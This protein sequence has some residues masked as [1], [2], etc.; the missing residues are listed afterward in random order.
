LTLKMLLTAVVSLGFAATALPAAAAEEAM[1]M[2]MANC[3]AM[4][5]ALPAP[6]AGWTTKAPLTAAAQV[7]RVPGAPLPP[8]KAFT[9]TL[10]PASGVSFP[11]PP[12]KA[13]DAASH[14]GLFGLTVKEAGTYRVALG[15]GAW[16][17]LV[18]DD[19]AVASS[20]HAHGPACSTVRKMVDFTLP[21]GDYVVQ[22]SGSADL[23]V[24]IM[25]ARLP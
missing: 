5:T 4:D 15:A 1:A 18:K 14:A 8:G 11:A 12:A 24:A 19:K 10:L 7:S 21:P 16:I 3:A 23:K 17:D 22:I 6:L 2:P 13:G 25:V 9:A 20:A